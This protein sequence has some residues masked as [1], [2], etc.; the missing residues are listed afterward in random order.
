MLC[1]GSR[2]G[3]RAEELPRHRLCEAG[4]LHSAQGSSCGSQ[5]P[6][7]AALWG[8]FLWD[9]R[10]AASVVLCR[11]NSLG[12]CGKGKGRFERCQ[13]KSDAVADF[14]LQPLPALCPDVI[15]VFV[16]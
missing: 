12:W 3:G 8:C 15:G 6:M 11:C 1:L 7:L 2:C 14:L 16:G 10:A 4:P 13:H 9:S 5:S